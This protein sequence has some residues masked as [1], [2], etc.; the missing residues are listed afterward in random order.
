[1]SRLVATAA[2]AARERPLGC[3]SSLNSHHPV[4]RTS[5]NGRPGSRRPGPPLRVG[6]D[7]GLRHWPGK[8]LCGWLALFF[9]LLF[10]FF[11]FFYT[12]FLS[13]SFF[14]ILRWESPEVQVPGARERGGKNKMNNNEKKKKS[15][16]PLCPRPACAPPSGEHQE[17]RESGWQV[18]GWASQAG[19]K[20]PALL[21]AASPSHSHW[22]HSHHVGKTPLPIL[23]GWPLGP[24]SWFEPI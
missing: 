21:G 4:P 20:E 6:S 18:W 3:Q 2:T 5:W 8:R 13:F 9:S 15:L 12:F 7:F 1:M 22:W 16:L 17:S 11:F 14:L 19:F 10:V 24:G 23:S